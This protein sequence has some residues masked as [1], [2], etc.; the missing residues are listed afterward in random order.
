MTPLTVSEH[1]CRFRE[2]FRVWV[3]GAWG[4]ELSVSASSD[5]LTCYCVIASSTSANG[6]GAAMEVYRPGFAEHSSAFARPLNGDG[7]AGGRGGPHPV[8][9]ETVTVRESQ[10]PKSLDPINHE[11]I[12]HYSS[13]L[14]IAEDRIPHTLAIPY[15]RQGVRGSLELHS[16]RVRGKAWKP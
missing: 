11:L 7:A 12:R 13:H 9:Y 2:Q 5:F 15:S 8:G 3:F 16:V 4:S 14:Y 1:S 10:A 6:H